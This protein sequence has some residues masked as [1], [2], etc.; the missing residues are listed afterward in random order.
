MGSS[1]YYDATWWS[2]GE[3]GLLPIVLAR[4]RPIPEWMREGREETRVPRVVNVDMEEVF[5]QR[6]P[7]LRSCPHFFRGC[8][9][10]SFRTA[11]EEVPGDHQGDELAEERAWTLFA[12]VMLLHR[13]RKSGQ[14]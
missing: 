9:R 11:L 5:T 8:L 14:R 6:V 3:E 13:F 1:G 10:N 2:A 7:M 12:L 4:A